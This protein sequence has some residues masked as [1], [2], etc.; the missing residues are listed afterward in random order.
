MFDKF[1]VEN[2]FDNS[3]FDKWFKSKVLDIPQS[4]IEKIV[5]KNKV[6]VNKKR[7]KTSHRVQYKDVVTVYGLSKIKK[8]T[9]LKK[10]K[11]KATF[12]EKN[13]YNDFILEDNDN[14]IV[15][16]NLGINTN[17]DDMIS[18]DLPFRQTYS[19]YQS[20][21]PQHIGVIVIVVEADTPEF[22]NEA[23]KLLVDRIN[24]EKD[25]FIN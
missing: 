22:T 24:K 2:D 13:E 6:K 18:R 25:F 12:K 7:T 11:Y 21:F 15:I 3:R 10:E 23:A 8:S 17:V 4:L 9:K 16:N 1:I 20:A 5:R 19:K 14:F